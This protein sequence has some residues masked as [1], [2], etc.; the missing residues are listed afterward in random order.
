MVIGPL[1]ASLI[2]VILLFVVSA[3]FSLH[4]LFEL[5]VVR[6]RHVDALHLAGLVDAFVCQSF[7]CD[8]SDSGH[9]CGRFALQGLGDVVR[10]LFTG[11]RHDSGFSREIIPEMT[12]VT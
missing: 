7:A 1:L 8:F 6:L 2:G 11:G 3:A 10:M 5:S 9:S 12:I 4:P